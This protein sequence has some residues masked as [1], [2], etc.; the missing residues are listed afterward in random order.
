M[1]MHRPIDAPDI[2]PQ[3]CTCSDCEFD[4]MRKRLRADLRLLLIAAGCALVVVAALVI[5]GAH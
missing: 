2:H 5:A 4:A 1:T 3:W